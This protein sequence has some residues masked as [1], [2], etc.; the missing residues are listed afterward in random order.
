MSEADYNLLIVGLPDA[1]KTSYIHAVDDLL[2]HPHTPDS[3]RS[4]ALAPDRSYLERDKADFR[5]GKKLLHTERNLQGPVPE[6]WF[7]DPSTGK[8]GKLFLPDVSGEVFQDQWVDRK[9]AKSYSDSLQKLSGILLFLRADLPASNQELLGELAALPEVE[10]TAKPFDPR[11][12]SAQVQLV[13]VLQFIA[14]HSALPTYPLKLCVMISAWDTV[15]HPGNMQPKIP[16]S[17]LARE[18]PLLDQYLKTNRRKFESRIFGVSALGGTPKE[19]EE[20][21]GELP[22]QQRVKIVFGDIESKDL[23]APLRWL[24][25]V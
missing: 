11:K 4:H 23:T 10:R 17:F 20:H 5:S 14:E 1:G 18:W 15:Y 8:R 9:W 2:Q 7:E 24:L 6:L 22:P 21:L 3:L 13:D 12:A 25:G 16:S 19:L